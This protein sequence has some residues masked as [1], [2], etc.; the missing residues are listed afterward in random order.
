KTN[1][2]TLTHEIRHNGGLIHPNEDKARIFGIPVGAGPT[3]NAPKTNFMYQGA[4]PNPT[5]PTRSQIYRIYLLYH[6]GALNGS[7]WLKPWNY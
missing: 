2:K 1:T 4:I 3:A 5:G 6:N 7:G